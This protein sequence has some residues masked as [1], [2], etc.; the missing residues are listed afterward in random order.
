M[1]NDSFLKTVE[2]TDQI[3]G[4]YVVPIESEKVAI[5]KR[6]P[7]KLYGVLLFLAATIS[8]SA[9]GYCN[10]TYGDGGYSGYVRMFHR[11]GAIKT[12]EGELDKRKLGGS[13]NAAD[14]FEFSV[15]ND[16]VAQK[17]QDAEQSGEWVTVHYKQ[18]LVTLPWRGKTPF[19]V[20]NV[21]HKDKPQ[22]ESLR[23]SAIDALK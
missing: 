21:T 19:I 3:L 9:Y 4:K 13:Y 16:A 10:Y 20:Y 22:D 12:W 14:I 17:V 18:Y 11:V 15:A 8:L 6:R 7:W 2:Q 5:V 23:Q 1:A